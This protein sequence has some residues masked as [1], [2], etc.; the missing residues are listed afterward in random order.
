[1]RFL[2]IG[3]GLAGS[4]LAWELHRRNVDFLVV[5]RPLG[6]T[7][8]RVAAGLVNPMMGKVF[9]AGWRQAECMERAQEFYPETESRLG[10]VWWQKCPIW[11]ELAGDDECEIWRERQ[12]DEHTS[13]WA[14]PMLPWPANWEGKGVAGYTTGSYVLHAENF[15]NSVRT[16]L[17]KLQ[18]F[19]ET[20]ILPEDIIPTEK[21]VI[22]QG[23]EFDR[24]IWATGW[25]VCRHPHM[26]PLSGRPSKG[27]IIDIELPGF[28]WN[29]GI[30]HYGHWL[31]YTHNIWRL[32]ATYAWVW[33]NTEEAD[34][35]APIELLTGLAQ[36]W[37]GT[38]IVH[39]YRSA[40]R[41]TIRRSQP[42]AGPIPHLPHQIVF[43]GLGSKGVTTAPWVAKTLV[44]YLLDDKELPSDLT[45]D[46]LWKT[47][48]NKPKRP[49]PPPSR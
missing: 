32:G 40:V 1:M 26:S 41:P 42:V 37:K 12:Q 16:W 3:Q 7:A 10:G 34:H 48:L 49:T 35:A 4:T 18:K 44:E 15:T 29:A 24:V 36:H 30:L 39:R 9:R 5:D 46:I 38:P 43:S 20:S 21:G 13:C 23:Q 47:A 19:K 33:D 45:P 25:E 11:R 2:I 14:G 22:W 6:E 17:I 31:V 27:T 8:S 28:D